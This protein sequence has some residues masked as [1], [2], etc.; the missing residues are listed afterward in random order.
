M[1]G[2][3]PLFHVEHHSEAA[4]G[5]AASVTNTFPL[6][7]ALPHFFLAGPFTLALK[8]FPPRARFLRAV[9]DGDLESMSRS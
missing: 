9:G 4:V 5:S 3:R 6:G 7:R 1:A 8:A 2:H